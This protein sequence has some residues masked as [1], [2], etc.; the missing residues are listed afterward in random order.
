MADRSIEAQ[1]ADLR[2]EIKELRSLTQGVEFHDETASSAVNTPAKSTRTATSA[3]PDIATTLAS[4]HAEVLGN[5]LDGESDSLTDVFEDATDDTLP[6]LE[7]ELREAPRRQRRDSGPTPQTVNQLFP[8]TKGPRGPAAIR[9]PRNV[10]IHEWSRERSNTVNRMSGTYLSHNFARESNIPASMT[11]V[12]SSIRQD[13]Q[14]RCP[15]CRVDYNHL[16]DLASASE[17]PESVIRRDHLYP[18]IDELDR[19]V[20][21]YHYP[22]V[23]YLACPSG[24]RFGCLTTD[25]MKEH[26]RMDSPAHRQISGYEASLNGCG[27][28]DE[29]FVQ[30]LLEQCH[31]KSP[32]FNPLHRV[33]HLPMHTRIVPTESSSVV[34]NYGVWPMAN[35]IFTQRAEVEDSKVFQAIQGVK[36]VPSM[37]HKR[38]TAIHAKL[39]Q[40]CRN[41]SYQMAGG[42]RIQCPTG[43]VAQDVD[44]Y[45][46]GCLTGTDQLPARRERINRPVSYAEASREPARHVTEPT[47]TFASRDIRYK[48]PEPPSPEGGIRDCPGGSTTT[49]TPTTSS[50][51]GSYYPESR[52]DPSE[53]V[54]TPTDVSDDGMPTEWH[55]RH[56]AMYKGQEAPYAFPQRPESERYTRISSDTSRFLG[57]Y[58]GPRHQTQTASFMD[59]FADSVVNRTFPGMETLPNHLA[60]RVDTSET[61][62]CEEQRER[63][64]AAWD[65][66]IERA[67]D[68]RHISE[69]PESPEH[70]VTQLRWSLVNDLSSHMRDAH[71][72][73]MST[74]S[75]LVE[76]AVKQAEVN[77]MPTAYELGRQDAESKLHLRLQETERDLDASRRELAAVQQEL[78]RSRAVNDQLRSEV[79]NLQRTRVSPDPI[80]SSTREE[81]PVTPSSADTTTGRRVINRLL[82][83]LDRAVEKLPDDVE[84]NFREEVITVGRKFGMDFTDSI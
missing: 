56:H 75:S 28:P 65:E 33:P 7:E 83:I 41:L 71:D 19:H 10:R 26:L 66:R 12:L 62:A 58:D 13:G 30:G 48:H 78:G 16:D 17:W 8:R 55:V 76:D 54:P 45:S 49:E 67:L 50:S 29:P 77:V 80:L 47:V 43:V 24:D 44:Q 27:M 6:D 34:Y 53:I 25:A 20:L 84:N 68:S 4:L 52:R 22:Y 57:D 60:T 2:R 36:F 79:H 40:A 5:A 72:V 81:S 46:A 35:R 14:F 15:F 42:I 61:K 3:F 38:A 21:A 74:F 73:M 23:R 31:G 82:G 39:R 51:E 69:V 18:D 70:S 64:L 59:K 1:G 32:I 37:T 63:Y 11:K 9:Q